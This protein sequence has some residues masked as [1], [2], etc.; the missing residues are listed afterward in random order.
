MNFLCQ[1][2][3]KSEHYSQIERCDCKHHHA[4]FV[5]DENYSTAFV[6]L[7]RNVREIIR[8]MARERLLIITLL[9]ALQNLPVEAV[10]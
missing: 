2:C 9:K 10:A 3:Q 5:G 8:T 7:F 4:A 6:K 1:G